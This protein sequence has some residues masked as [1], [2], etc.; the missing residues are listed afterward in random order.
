MWFFLYTTPHVTSYTP[1]L[2]PSLLRSK[3]YKGA[4]RGISKALGWEEL[5]KGGGAGG[6]GRGRGRSKGKMM[7]ISTMMVE[8]VE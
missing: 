1:S 5:K 4:S 2:P 3:Q 8:V 7:P 6:E